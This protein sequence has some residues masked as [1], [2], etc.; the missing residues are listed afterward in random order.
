MD[1]HHRGHNLYVRGSPSPRTVHVSHHRPCYHRLLRRIHRHRATQ[2][3]QHLSPHTMA[4]ILKQLDNSGACA[5]EDYRRGGNPTIL[6]ASSQHG[7]QVRHNH[8]ISPSGPRGWLT[9]HRQRISEPRGTWRSRRSIAC[10]SPARGNQAK[11]RG[12]GK[13]AGTTATPPSPHHL[14]RQDGVPCSVPDIGSRP[15]ARANSRRNG[16]ASCGVR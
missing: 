14:M 5:G 3:R 4:T 16:T 12:A 13:K 10:R 6:H 11:E 8:S 1:T 15:Y 9:P 7:R 2:L